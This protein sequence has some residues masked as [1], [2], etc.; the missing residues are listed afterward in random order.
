M[1]ELFHFHEHIGKFRVLIQT[2]DINDKAITGRKIA[3][4]VIEVREG[5]ASRVQTNAHPADALTV[6]W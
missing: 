6:E 1:M 2:R 3:D 4:R 5:K